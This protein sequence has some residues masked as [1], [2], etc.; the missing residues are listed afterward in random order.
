[1][2]TWFQTLLSNG[3]TCAAYGA[4]RSFNAVKSRWQNVLKKKQTTTS[5]DD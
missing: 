3:S 5:D 4:G 1:V 2:K